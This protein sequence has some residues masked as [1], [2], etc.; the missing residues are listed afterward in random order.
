M[1]KKLW[2]GRFTKTL[3]NDAVDLSYSLQ[4]DYQLFPYDIKTNQ[5]YAAAL[6][7]KGILT[8]PEYDQL[9]EALSKL[10][11]DVTVEQLL[12]ANDEDVHSFVER[13][14]T[15]MCGDVGKKLHTGKSRNDQVMTDIRLFKRSPC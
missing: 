4:F 6:H 9:S 2:G 10:A 8:K 12:A 3:D 5:A 7:Q 14:V 15:E 1:N 11:S 13:S